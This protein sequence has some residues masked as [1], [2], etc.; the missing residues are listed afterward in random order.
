MRNTSSTVLILLVGEISEVLNDETLE[1]SDAVRPG[2][3]DASVLLNVLMSLAFWN[4]CKVV[5]KLG[6]AD[7]VVSESS[8]QFSTCC[9]LDKK[10][11]S[12]VGMVNTVVL[13]RG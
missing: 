11:Q 12:G 3:H 5:P 6:P 4:G 13:G 8:T 2:Q 7:E 10:V 1:A 9:A